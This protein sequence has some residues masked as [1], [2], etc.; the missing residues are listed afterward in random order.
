[1]GATLK[2]GIGVD[3]LADAL[4]DFKVPCVLEVEFGGRGQDWAWV[5][6]GFHNGKDEA[7]MNAVKALSS[8]IVD[9]G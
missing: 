2:E 6:E 5:S 9:T 1:M 7:G 8:V 3:R 4:G